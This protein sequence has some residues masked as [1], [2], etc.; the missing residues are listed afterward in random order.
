MISLSSTAEI[1]ELLVEAGLQ[2][3]EIEMCELSL[4]MPEISEFVAKHISA[5][6]MSKSFLASSE[7][8]QNVLVKEVADNLAMYQAETGPTVPFRIQV[9]KAQK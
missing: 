9:A 2:N 3:I 7:S 1:E 8:L 4:Q 5:T 6:P